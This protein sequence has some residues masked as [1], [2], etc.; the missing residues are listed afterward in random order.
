MPLETVAEWK[1]HAKRVSDEGN[2]NDG[3]EILSR[4]REES[5]AP[6]TLQR[7]R[8]DRTWNEELFRPWL[9]GRLCGPNLEFL[10]EMEKYKQYPSAALAQTIYDRFVRTGVTNVSGSME[11]ALTAACTADPP[12]DRA[13]LFDAVYEEMTKLTISQYGDFQIMVNRVG[14]EL[15]AETPSKPVVIDRAGP[16][17]LTRTKIDDS[18]VKSWNERALKDLKALKGVPRTTTFYQSGKLLIVVHPKGK[19]A[20]QPYLKWA[21]DQP[22]IDEGTLTIEGGTFSRASI[23][24]TGVEDQAA[25]RTAMAAC[26]TMP[27]N[28]A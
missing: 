14:A 17:E 5:G 23:T 11:E 12:S 18:V 3:N 27:V 9:E 7:C 19:E 28:F 1:A 20:G 24:A 22:D 15:N 13:D 4:L 6:E 16:N 8:E 26:S 21:D 25:F 2:E 10:E